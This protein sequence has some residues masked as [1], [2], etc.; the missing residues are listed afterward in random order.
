MASNSAEGTQQAATEI[1]QIPCPRCT[2]VIRRSYRYISLLNQRER[3]IQG[4]IFK[5]YIYL[6]HKYQIAS[7]INLHPNFGSIM[8][9][10]S[11]EVTKVIT[12]ITEDN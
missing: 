11:E 8:G 4:V 9:E 3:D 5:I 1:I 7:E 2:T 12:T 6:S 10:A